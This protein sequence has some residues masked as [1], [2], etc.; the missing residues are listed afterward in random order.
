MCYPACKERAVEAN[1]DEGGFYYGCQAV[2]I[3]GEV[4]WRE[5]AG[6]DDKMAPGKCICDNFL[7]DVLAETVIGALP[8]IA[9]VCTAL[10]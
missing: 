1:T 2:L 4:P 6:T 5:V 9:Q 10:G 7:V 8:A 3:N